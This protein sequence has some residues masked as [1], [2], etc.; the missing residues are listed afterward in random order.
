M[1]A[2]LSEREICRTRYRHFRDNEKRNEK[3]GEKKQKKKGERENW[4]S[5]HESYR[6]RE[7]RNPCIPRRANPALLLVYTDAPLVSIIFLLPVE[8]G[9]GSSFSFVAR[10][11]SYDHPSLLS[12]LSISDLGISP[13]FLRRVSSSF[14]RSLSPSF[15]SNVSLY[16]VLLKNY[17]SKPLWPF[18]LSFSLSLL[19]FLPH[20]FSSTAYGVRR[21]GFR[22][23]CD[24]SSNFST[25][26]LWHRLTPTT[27]ACFSWKFQN[28]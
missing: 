1:Y 7:A 3:K 13:S 5:W 12:T 15:V 25:V 18:F 19:F 28:T 6:E 10:Y 22:R 14:S 11:Y 27:T 16:G 20:W 4:S 2:H 8:R 26:A 21:R 9:R 23:D 24:F 17:T